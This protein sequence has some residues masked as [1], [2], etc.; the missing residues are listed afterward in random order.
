MIDPLT[1]FMALVYA[2]SRLHEKDDEDRPIPIPSIEQSRAQRDFL[3]Q[4]GIEKKEDLIALGIR[5]KV[6]REHKSEMW[7]RK[8]AERD[9]V[10]RESLQK[11]NE[12]IEMRQC[13]ASVKKYYLKH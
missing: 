8:M 9:R 3:I 5:P 11:L 2:Y 1:I 7:L 6:M 10:N 12:S 4:Y 13:R